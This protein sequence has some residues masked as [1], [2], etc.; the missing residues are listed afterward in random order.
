[1]RHVSRSIRRSTIVSTDEGCIPSH[2]L[3][4]RQRSIAR[5]RVAFGNEL[6]SIT[7]PFRADRRYKRRRPRRAHPCASIVLGDQ[8]LTTEPPR[9][10]GP[11]DT[12]RGAST[13]C[14][15][16]APCGSAIVRALVCDRSC[17]QLRSRYRLGTSARRALAGIGRLSSLAAFHGPPSRS[18]CRGRARSPRRARRFRPQSME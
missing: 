16:G 17:Q 13:S 12:D 1:M 7:R 18:G 8:N 11:C 14:K 15:L 3:E 6:C 5:E 2:L 4:S 9:S 10:K